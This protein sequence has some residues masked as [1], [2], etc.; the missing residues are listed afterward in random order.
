MNVIVG[1]RKKVFVALALAFVVLV[2]VGLGL[3]FGLKGSEF[4]WAIENL[5]SHLISNTNAFIDLDDTSKQITLKDLKEGDSFSFDVKL[6]NPTAENYNYRLTMSTAKNTMVSSQ[7]DVEVEVAEEEQDVYGSS[8][9]ELR[10]ASVAAGKDETIKVTVTAGADL[11]GL[12][13]SVLKIG[14]KAISETEDR[15]ASLSSEYALVNDKEYLEDG[16]SSGGNIFLSGVTAEGQESYQFASNL[17]LKAGR[18][19]TILGDASKTPVIDLGEKTIIVEPGAELELQNVILRGHIITKTEESNGGAQQQAARATS[20][21]SNLVLNNVTIYGS[22]ER[23]N[24]SGTL[25][26][27]NSYKNDT[28]P[29]VMIEEDT[30]LEIIGNV[31]VVGNWDAAGIGVAEDAKVEITGDNLVAIGNGGYEVINAEKNAKYAVLTKQQIQDLSADAEFSAHLAGDLDIATNPEAFVDMTVNGE[32]SKKNKYGVGSGSG[33]G[34]IYGNDGA[35][36]GDIYIH[37]LK[38]LT[39]E[40]YGAHAFGVGGYSD[41]ELVIE[42]TTI[43][44]T[45]GGYAIY[46]AASGDTSYGSNAPEGGAAI[47]LHFASEQ[48]TGAPAIT[49]K[50]VTIGAAYGGSKAAGI[51]A[52]FWSEIKINIINSKIDKVVGGVSGAGIGGSRIDDNSDNYTIINI[53]DSTIDALGGYL[54]AAI[55]SGYCSNV[56]RPDRN[57][58]YKQSPMTTIN[59]WGASN[60]TAQGGKRAAAIGTG[61]HIP[62]LEGMIGQNVVINATAGETD[63]SSYNTPE[64]V[65]LGA[66]DPTRDGSLVID[67]LAKVVEVQQGDKTIKVLAS[68]TPEEIQAA[69]D[70]YNAANASVEGFVPIVYE[71]GKDYHVKSGIVMDVAES[72]FAG[73]L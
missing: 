50:D 23:I 4:A 12:G 51:G 54:S 71:E 63:K 19:L 53:K 24:K 2:A 3:V 41:G 31:K 66:L 70:A 1:R 22:E 40:G 45:R 61:Y 16:F 5:D 73:I 52:S 21:V 14:L 27:G 55:G 15:N 39:A 67:N 69:I 8:S 64:A 35:R 6:Q 13:D 29:A 17:V 10:A 32:T 34:A 60:I 59:I 47:G 62:N 36:V 28:K 58:Q 7:L 48:D 68:K 38:S 9:R 57:D 25:D 65:G 46:M 56:R 37:D 18:A 30:K 33:I 26:A 20:S 72:E 11:T 42:N 44:K 43:E 49:L